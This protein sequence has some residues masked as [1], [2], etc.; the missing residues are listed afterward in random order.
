MKHHSAYNPRVA[1]THDLP[2]DV[3]ALK[4]LVL[5]HRRRDQANQLEIERLKIQLSR[6]RRWKFD[7]SSEQLRLQIAQLEMSLEALQ[8]VTPEAA[9]P[10]KATEATPQRKSQPT[11]RRQRPGR[12]ALPAHLP[13]ETIYH[14]HP[15]V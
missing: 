11:P 5:E 12:R 10:Q 13:R 7:R 4:R 2:D 3:L 1:D 9:P 6:F 8:A 15:V 14:P